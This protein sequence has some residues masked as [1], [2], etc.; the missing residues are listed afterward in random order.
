MVIVDSCHSGGMTRSIRGKPVDQLELTP[1]IQ[2][3]YLAMEIEEVDSKE[4]TRGKGL[5]LPKRE[6]IEDRISILS[7]RED[8]ISVEMAF[9]SGVVH[10]AFTAALLE[11]IEGKKD[12]SYG[13]WFDRAKKTVKDKFRLEQDPQL[14][15]TRGKMLTQAVFKS[16]PPAAGPQS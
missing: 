5:S 10:G 4:M 1:A 14:K 8:Q 6:G 11:G 2:S 7:S 16:R 9:P 12:I 15:T 3:K 13:E